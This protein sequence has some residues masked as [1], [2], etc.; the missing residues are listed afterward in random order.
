MRVDQ[1]DYDALTSDDRIE[2]DA[3]LIRHDLLDLGVVAVEIETEGRLLIEH[4]SDADG[5]LNEWHG[6]TLVLLHT[7]ITA[8]PPPFPPSAWHQ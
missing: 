1:E 2:V 4:F 3:W 8:E 5:N 6:D 7:H